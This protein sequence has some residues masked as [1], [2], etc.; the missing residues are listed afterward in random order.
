MLKEKDV[1]D[2]KIK[3]LDEALSRLDAEERDL[4][5]ESFLKIAHAKT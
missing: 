2:E 4:L 5:L 1:L 3:V